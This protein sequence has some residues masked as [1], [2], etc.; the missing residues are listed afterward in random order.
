[1]IEF[2]NQLSRVNKLFCGILLSVVFLSSRAAGDFTFESQKTDSMSQLVIG[3][4]LPEFTMTNT[5][6]DTITSQ[7]LKGKITVINFWFKDCAPCILELDDLH[8]LISKFENNPDFQYLSFTIDSNEKAKQA[9]EELGITYDVYPITSEESKRLFCIA[10]PTNLIIDQE[11]KVVY[12]KTGI[13][14][15]NIHVRQMELM[16]AFLLTEKNSKSPYLYSVSAS[17]LPDTLIRIEINMAM[18][19]YKQLEASMSTAIGNKYFDFNAMTLQGKRITQDDLQGKITVIEFWEELCLPCVAL[20]DF[21]N[22][23]Y[24][25]HKTNPY[26]QLFTFTNDLKENT[27]KVVDKHNLLFDVVCVDSEEIYHLNYQTGFPSVLIINPNGIVTYLKIRGY[28]EEE[29]KAMELEIDNLL[30]EW[31][32]DN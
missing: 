14:L 30:Q 12:L 20:F 2:E 26:F 16:T 6:G 21:F 18:E 31:F 17:I 32:P 5:N 7:S 27:K 19:I 13:S 9:M 25:R 1:M 29:K 4:Y 22:N 3:S 8:L 15:N 10:F 23:L 24:L 11:G 28:K